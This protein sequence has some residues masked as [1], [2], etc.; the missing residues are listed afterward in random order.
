M[1]E[2]KKEKHLE[3]GVAVGLVFGAAFGQ[4]FPN[5]FNE[6]KDRRGD[7]ENTEHE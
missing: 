6:E 2:N 1:S 4:V 3:N 7:A 5:M